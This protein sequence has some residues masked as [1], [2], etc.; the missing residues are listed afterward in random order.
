MALNNIF[1]EPRR[2]LT[3]QLVGLLLLVPVGLYGYLVYYLASISTNNTSDF[4]GALIV[5]TFGLIICFFIL[6]GILLLMHK[7]GE[8]I[9]EELD[10]FGIKLRPKQRY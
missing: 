7:V 4:C 5:F 3:E 2:E 6:C 1:R 8:E 9:C 10:S